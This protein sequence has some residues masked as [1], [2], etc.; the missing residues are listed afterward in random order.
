MFALFLL[1]GTSHSGFDKKCQVNPLSIMYKYEV[2]HFSSGH[3]QGREGERE[4]EREGGRERERE[5][6]PKWPE[7]SISEKKNKHTTNTQQQ[8]QQQQ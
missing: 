4:R 3:C 2:R 6:V 7:I 5:R 8:Q 1:A